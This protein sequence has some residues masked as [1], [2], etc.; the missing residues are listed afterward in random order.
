V[1]RQQLDTAQAQAQSGQ[2]VEKPSD[3]PQAFAHAQQ[4]T[5]QHARAAQHEKAAGSA[6][7]SLQ[8]ADGALAD[9]DNLLQRARDIAVEG[10]SDTLSASDRAGL[11]QEVSQLHDQLVALGNTQDGSRYLFAGY[12]DGSAPFDSAGNYSGD[13]SGQQVEVAPGVTLPLGLTG[14]RVFAAAG[15]QDLFAALT[16]LQTALGGSSAA[17]TSATISTLDLGLE[18]LRSSRSQ[19]GNYMNAAEAAQSVA[20]RVQDTATQSR[21]KLV[22]ID[23]A[24][25][26]TNL[27]QAQSALSAAVQIAGQLPPPGLVERAR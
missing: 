5:A 21:S 14:D 6:L 1:R 18:Q 4:Y 16:S 9:V 2:R 25:A 24:V 17:N 26:Y 8:T 19:L 11:A 7:S 13:V 20:Q 23:A 12:K 22:D 15:G 27:A 10:A 3:D